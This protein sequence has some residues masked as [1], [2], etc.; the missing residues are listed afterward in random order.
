[1]TRMLEESVRGSLGAG[2]GGVLLGPGDEGYEAARRVHNGMIDKRPAL[3]ARCTGVADVRAALRFGVDRG[4]RSRFGAAVTMW[5]G[6]QSA[7]TG[8]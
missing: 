6:T 7:M 1:M 3:I 2:F 8:S 4:C 5:P